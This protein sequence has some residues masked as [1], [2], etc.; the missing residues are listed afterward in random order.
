L[1]SLSRLAPTGNKKSEDQ[2]HERRWIYR[3]IYKD[4]GCWR[5]PVVDRSVPAPKV[6][7]DEI[8][9]TTRIEKEVDKLKRIIF[10]IIGTLLVLGL[11]LPGCGEV[12]PAEN[13]ITI[14][15]C[16]PLT[17]LQGQNHRDGAEMAAEEI[18][19]AGGVD[20]GGTL[21]DVELVF[22]ETEESTEGED[23][24]T[25]SANLEAV[26]DDVTF[27][28]G[29]FRTEVVSVYREV[30]MDAQKLFMNC[31]AA[32]GSLQ[33]S[34]VTDYDAYK[35]WFKATPYNETFLVKSLLKMQGTIGAFLKGTLQTVE[36]MNSTYVKNE[37]KISLAVGNKVRVHILMEDAAWCAGMVAAAQYYLPLIGF[38]VTGTTLVSP[39]AADLTTELGAIKVLYPHMI[40]TA[41][42][43]SVGAVYSNQKTALGIP[44]VT[45]GI[46][47]PGQQLSHWASTDGDC[48]GEIML[49]TWAVGL[50]QTATTADWFNAYLDRTDRY[51]VY[52]AGTYDAIHFVC[53]AIDETNSLDSD[54][55]IPYLEDI[56]NAYTEGVSSPK[57]A[58]YP[59]PA[60]N[61]TPGE[62]Y[63][64]SEAQVTELYDL[65]SYGWAYNQSHWLCGFVSGVQQ[66]HIAHDIAYGPGLVTGIGSQ[67]QKLE[68]GTG[69]PAKV[70]IWPFDLPGPSID[71]YGDWDFAY[72]GTTPY[73][74][75]I[76]GM[77][78]IPWD[79]Y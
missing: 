30:A 50:E 61:I 24:S 10:L 71:Q 4:E 75:T 58:Y 41:F 49:D 55:L 43:G 74:L 35:Y 53:Q 25:G 28:V 13:V 38:T 14:A 42:S 21:Y 7:S 48:E 77:L 44:A 18:N 8:G 54:V 47:V 63:G 5:Q 66:P 20:V 16:G 17:D 26:I 29:G 1:V 67:W 70:G 78:N 57:V 15:V 51:P 12:P 23:G 59:M 2:K 3:V 6:R 39:T 19:D 52:T 11:V 40:F 32:T 37:F 62:L 33:F 27:C 9:A 69:A 60:N 34:V 46:N 72:T 65:D 56:D 22:V 36:A 45:L 76:G 73:I 64:L 68:A 79:P 31:G